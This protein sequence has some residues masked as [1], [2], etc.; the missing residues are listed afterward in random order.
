MGTLVIHNFRDNFFGI[1]GDLATYFALS[2]GFSRWGCWG[3]TEDLANLNTPKYR[4]IEEL[5][6]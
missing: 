3:A 5:V 4:A 2:S 6:K 1:G